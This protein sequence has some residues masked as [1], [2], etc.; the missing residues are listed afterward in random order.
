[1]VTQV[2]CIGVYKRGLANRVLHFV[3]VCPSLPPSDNVVRNVQEP[4]AHGEESQL[5]EVNYKVV[6]LLKHVL[7]DERRPVSYLLV[8]R[9]L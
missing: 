9:L 5:D 6:V 2:I 4:P 3:G 7:R 8:L 1:M